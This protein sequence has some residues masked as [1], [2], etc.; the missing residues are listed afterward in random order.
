MGWWFAFTF[1]LPL[2]IRI[3]FFHNVTVDVL[4]WWLF[5]LGI[6]FV[7]N[8]I[9]TERF[10]Y[11]VAW[12]LLMLLSSKAKKHLKEYGDYDAP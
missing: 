2:A 12:L 1:S 8:F 9:I 7:L 10:V 11:N 4:I 5:G 6:S 3:V